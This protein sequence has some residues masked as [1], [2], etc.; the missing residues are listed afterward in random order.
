MIMSDIKLYQGD[1]LDLMKNIPDSSV[2]LVVTSPP[3]EDMRNYR[4]TNNFTFEVF[5]K[6]ADALY[7]V[8]VSGGV[9]IWVVG[10]KTENG[11]ETGVSFRQAL[12]FKKIGF[13]L[14]DTM[15]YRKVNYIPLTHNRYEQEFEYMFCFSKGRPKTFNPIRVQC[16][17][18]GQSQWGNATFYKTDDDQLVDV[19]QNVIHDTKI[20]GNIFEYQVGSTIETKHYSHP[21]MFPMKLVED[22]IN[23]WSNEGDTV[24]D[25][26]MGSGTTGVACKKLNR[27]FIGVELVPNYFKIA[28]DRINQ[29]LFPIRLF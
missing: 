14:H 29:A 18:A 19:G 6:I 13:N 21:A 10:D 24:L 4:N 12:Y 25:P 22:Q 20:R 9:I 2:D 7:K 23:S 1:C 26:F 17:C 3:Y 5:T 8:V 15:I 11:S 28:E 16:K 27:N